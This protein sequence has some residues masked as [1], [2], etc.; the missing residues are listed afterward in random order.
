MSSTFA[1]GSGP[2][3][4][5]CDD[6]VGLRLLVESLLETGGFTVCAIAGTWEEAVQ[7][8]AEQRPDAVLLDLWMPRFEAQQLRRIRELVPDAVLAVVSS[9]SREEIRELVG[10]VEVPV[11]LSKHE[12]PELLVDEL[13][14]AVAARPSADGAEDF[15]T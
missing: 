12:I 3:V 8:T 14:R 13:K 4:L 15:G 5:V 11:M 9:H 2:R 6:A 7:L 10:D 1:T